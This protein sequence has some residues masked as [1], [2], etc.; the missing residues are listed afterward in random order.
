MYTHGDTQT[1]THMDTHKQTHTKRHTQ[2]AVGFLMT[3]KDPSII[4]LVSVQ[5]HEGRVDTSRVGVRGSGH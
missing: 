1:D 2:P 4:V 5:C 3:F